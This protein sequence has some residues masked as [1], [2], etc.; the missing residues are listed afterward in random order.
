M[1]AFRFCLFVFKLSLS[2]NRAVVVAK[3]SS[4]WPALAFL[5]VLITPR[6][7]VE[8]SS[9]REKEEEK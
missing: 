8:S 2:N 1:L 5:E 9:G 7:R 4:L 3:M 6:E